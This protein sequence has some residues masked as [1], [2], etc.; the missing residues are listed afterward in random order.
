M[1]LGVVIELAL[2]ECGLG[3]HLLAAEQ[4]D[5][6]LKKHQPSEG[7][8][9]LG[10]LHEARAQ[11]AVAMRDADGLEFH[12]ACLER[13]Y[14]TT[15]DRP[16]IA[17]VERFARAARREVIGTSESIDMNQSSEFDHPLTVVHRLRHGGESTL[18]G[19]AE[20]ILDQLLEYADVRAGHV[21]LWSADQLSCVASR[22][23]LPPS[24]AFVSVVAEQLCDDSEVLTAALRV[25]T[26]ERVRDR[27][28]LR[29]RGYRLLRLVTSPS[30]GAQLVGAL[31]L[32]EETLFTIPRTVLRVIADRIHGTQTASLT[33]R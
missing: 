10:E 15:N 25:A 8:L 13:W 5:A 32:S 16:L 30:S 24:D 33:L 27:I 31:L 18:E 3:R 23:D 29:G 26:D 28:V 7:P 20:W 22:G 11:V 4:L 2:A 17:R 9:T 1:N 6:L 12:L 19:S 21:Y 14:R